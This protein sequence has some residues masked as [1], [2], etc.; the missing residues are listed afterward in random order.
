MD[1]DR[2][3]FQVVDHDLAF[4]PPLFGFDL[5]AFGRIRRFL[6]RIEESQILFTLINLSHKVLFIPV[7]LFLVSVKDTK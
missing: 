5:R 7:L 4:K 3:A 1:R 2:I 6:N